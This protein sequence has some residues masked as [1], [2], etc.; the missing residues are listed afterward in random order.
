MLLS[1]TSLERKERIFSRFFFEIFSLR[2]RPCPFFH[3]VSFFGNRVDLRTENEIIESGI[4]LLL[5]RVHLPAMPC[6]PS[7]VLSGVSS[8][9]ISRVSFVC[10]FCV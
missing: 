5:S 9:L 6:I 10:A 7:P 2:T 1:P 8:S 4:I 3:G